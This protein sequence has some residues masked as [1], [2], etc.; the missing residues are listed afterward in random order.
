MISCGGGHFQW[1]YSKPQDRCLARVDNLTGCL[2]NERMTALAIYTATGFSPAH[3]LTFHTPS[4]FHVST[5]A[6]SHSRTKL[7]NLSRSR[8]LK[9]YHQTSHGRSTTSLSLLRLSTRF[10]TAHHVFRYHPPAI[11]A[12]SCHVYHTYLALFCS[13]LWL[14]VIAVREGCLEWVGKGV[15]FAKR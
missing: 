3:H 9:V 15:G 2:N 12:L 11:N 10:L 7:T 1:L 6:F 8:N 14:E 5:F 13:R 4:H